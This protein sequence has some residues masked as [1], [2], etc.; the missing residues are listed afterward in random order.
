[1]SLEWG[2]ARASTDGEGPAAR[3]KGMGHMETTKPQE[4]GRKTMDARELGL[5][6]HPLSH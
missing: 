6:G 2:E 5:K 4:D 3:A 1:M